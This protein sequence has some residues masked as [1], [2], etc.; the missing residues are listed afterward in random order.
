MVIQDKETKQQWCKMW[1]CS[2][3]AVLGNWKI[4][5]TTRDKSLIPFLHKAH[6][7]RKQYQ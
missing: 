4:L 7:E 6:I 3:K 2:A 1:V 5:F